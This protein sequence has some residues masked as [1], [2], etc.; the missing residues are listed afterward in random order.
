MPSR[1]A[2]VGRL[3]RVALA[4]LDRYPL[5]DGRLTFV[6]HGEN[7][8]FRHDNAAGRYLVRVHRPQ[9]HGSYVDST[10][11]VH[12]ELAWLRAF[13]TD[14]E[15]A[16]PEPL[17]AQDGALAVEA[18]GAGETRICSVLRWMDG[19]IHETSAHPVHLS[20]V[21]EAMGRLHDHADGWTPPPD[22]VRIRWDHETFFGDGMVYGE[23]PARGCWALL[24]AELRA[25][26]DSVAAR[27]ADV[28]PAVGGVG[29]I[30][31]D[32]HLGNVLFHR[33]GVRLIDFDDCG[34]GPRLYELAVALWE[35][36][37]RPD[38]D[39]FR[40]AL[41]S[42]YRRRRDIDVAHLDDFIALR[43]VAFDLWYTGMAEVNP[44]FAARL[45]K[46]HR[47]SLSMLDL[48]EAR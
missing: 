47:W 2:Q 27:M 19:R 39:V 22:F 17:A 18:S 29:L 9:R 15:L 37:D 42:G 11:A 43:Q 36:R 32:L 44:A 41:L 1:R 6:T 24:P 46:V 40:E 16:V 35:L 38:H 26:F 23:T 13:R 31:A 21:G 45:D 28:M 10:V 33:G 30:H 14:T 34:T 12:S 5:P 25:R 4:A 3:R 48:V 8:T 20:R 7:T